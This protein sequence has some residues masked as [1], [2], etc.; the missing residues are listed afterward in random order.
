[1]CYNI[2]NSATIGRLPGGMHMIL[3]IGT[4]LC[5]IGRMAR[6]ME[7]PRFAERLLTGREREPLARMSA[8]RAAEHMAGLFAAKEAVAKALGTGFS[9]FGFADIEVLPDGNGR[10]RAALLGRAAELFPDVRIH[11]SITHDEGLAQAFA[12]I[13]REERE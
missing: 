2:K 9:G 1:M 5:G 6:A 3:G 7:N 8:K 13:E 12:V 10:P 11:I 4:D